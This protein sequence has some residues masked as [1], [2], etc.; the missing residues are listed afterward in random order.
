MDVIVVTYNSAAVIEG[1][2]DSIPDALAGGHASVAVVDNAS[3]DDTAHVVAARTDCVLVPAPNL[4]YAAGVNRGVTQL[5]GSGPIL[6]TNPDVRLA[7]GSVAQMLTELSR[8]G[9]GIVVPRLHDPDGTV[10]RSL[11]REPTVA[12]SLGAG[13]SR[14]PR[15]SEIVNEPEAYE[16][17]HDIEWAT[18]AVMLVAR[19]CFDRLGGFDE[20]F[21]MYSEETDFCLRAQDA[22]WSVRFTPAAEAMHVGGASGR[23]PELYAM[24]VL[25]RIRLYRRRH[26]LAAT[27]A[28]VTLVGAREAVFALRGVPDSRRALESLCRP[29]RRPEQLRWSTGLLRRTSADDPPRPLRNGSGDRLP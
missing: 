23:N 27:S 13:D 18:G 20:S 19:E 4:G 6:V 29:S 10:A 9:V 1:L 24:Q 17:A 28:L 12:R 21:F 5:A 7:P 8:P 25:N 16:T 22:G 11:R 26:G 14:H 2:L 15:L 3:S